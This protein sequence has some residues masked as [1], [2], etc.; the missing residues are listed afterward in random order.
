MQI[1]NG[2]LFGVAPLGTAA[3]TLGSAI[4]ILLIVVEPEATAGFGVV[5]RSAY[6]ASH[7]F[8]G[9]A[10]C[11][12]LAVLVN[13][14]GAVGS[15]SR[16]K[17]SLVLVA[18]GLVAAA[19]A[20]PIFTLL[21]YFFPEG[22]PD[23]YWDIAG[24][25]NWGILVVGKF[26]DSCP[27][28]LAIW[29]CINMP[30]LLAKPSLNL[31]ELPYDTPPSGGDNEETQ[32][33]EE[34]LSRLDEFKSNLP[35]IIGQDVVA[36]S[37]D[38]HY[39]N[40]HTALGKTLLLGSLKHVAEIYADEGV[41]IHRSHWVRKEHVVRVHIRG[42]KAVCLMRNGLQIPIARSKRKEIKAMF[43]N[44]KKPANDNIIELNQQTK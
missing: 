31:H 7:M 29:L 3:L 32:R 16:V 12:L 34:R 36:I 43:G 37:S 22:E 11:L 14:F 27:T 8:V 38:L 21:S 40:I 18:M 9:C 28:F 20:S 33:E 44:A 26:I 6:W 19:M 25:N 10:I 41:L 24:Q 5:M 15:A 2:T 23:S 30:I 1:A 42:D 39:L 4:T 35:S 17:S 13:Q